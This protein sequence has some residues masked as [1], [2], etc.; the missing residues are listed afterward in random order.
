LVALSSDP[1][2]A[3]RAWTVAT[4]ATSTKIEA[5]ALLADAR[6]RAT[7]LA[8]TEDFI[9]HVRAVAAELLAHG[10]LTGTEVSQLL[11]GATDG[12]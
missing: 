1:T 5:H 12:T 2:D 3:E 8:G 11:E 7:R 6:D 10:E 4:A 9:E